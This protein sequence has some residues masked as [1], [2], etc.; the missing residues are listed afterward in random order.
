MFLYFF[1]SKMIF[2][3]EKLSKDHVFSFDGPFKE[4]NIPGNNGNNIH[5]LL[6]EA[7]NSKGLIFYLHGNAGSVDGWGDV[8]PR[9]TNLGYSVFIVDYPGYGKSEGRIKNT[10]GLL[11]AVEQ[12]YDFI[13]KE[14]S[15]KEMIVLGYSLGS[16]PAAYL[17]SVNHPKLLILQTPYYSIKDVMKRHY[18]IIPTFLLK[19]NW[20][21]YQYLESC[22]MPVIL[23]HGDQDEV[24]YHGSSEKLMKILKPEDRLITLKGQ[25]HNGMTDNP[26]YVQVLEEILN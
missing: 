3:P 6:F 2:F 24:I 12:A 20:K 18:P 4:I 5:G 25:G 10:R 15:E 21:T 7:E 8:A 11:S 16:G 17:A 23:I 22:S 14:Y 26:E 13:K 1:Q 19:Y 9:Y